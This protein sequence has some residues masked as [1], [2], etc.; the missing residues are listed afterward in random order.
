MVNVLP[1]TLKTTATLFFCHGRQSELAL[2]V[3]SDTRGFSDVLHTFTFCVIRSRVSHWED[4]SSAS[5][6][7]TFSDQGGRTTNQCIGEAVQIYTETCSST[8]AH[9]L[10]IDSM[11]DSSL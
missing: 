5:Q 9:C 10:P 7:E 2:C 8:R 1:E 3:V 4:D 6:T 11:D